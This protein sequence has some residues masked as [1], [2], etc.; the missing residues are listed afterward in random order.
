MQLTIQKLVSVFNFVV[1][2]HELFSI[3][4]FF[5]LIELFLYHVNRKY[6]ISPSNTIII[7]HYK[8]RHYIFTWYLSLVL[9]TYSRATKIYFCISEY[10][11]QLYIRVCPN[12]PF[13]NFCL[14]FKIKILMVMHFTLKT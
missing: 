8:L 10:A 2:R 13:Y 11:F 6:I 12:N 1:I 5:T 9:S 14:E 4:I 3:I 7:F